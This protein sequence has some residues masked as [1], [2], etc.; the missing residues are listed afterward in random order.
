MKKS[1][2]NTDNLS[3]G[4]LFEIKGGAIANPY[5]CDSQA[6]EVNACTTG[7]CKSAACKEKACGSSVCKTSTE[8]PPAT[9]SLRDLNMS[10]SILSA[11]NML[12]SNLVR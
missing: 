12:N 1:N 5:G 3:I 9:E 10:N 6:C 4:E 2:F 11:E 8:A 7:A